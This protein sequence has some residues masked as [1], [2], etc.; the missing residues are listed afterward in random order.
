MVC[1][2]A[3]TSVTIA[4]DGDLRQDAVHCMLEELPTYSFLLESVGAVS[5]AGE[6][7]II[8]TIMSC[9]APLGRDFNAILCFTDFMNFA[10]ETTHKAIGIV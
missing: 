4:S 8:I 7:I 5:S 2:G 6:A 10:V 9:H 3:T 1:A